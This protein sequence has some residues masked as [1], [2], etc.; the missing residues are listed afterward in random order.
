MKIDV[1]F[2]R[3][4]ARFLGDATA[5]EFTFQVLEEELGPDRPGMDF[6]PGSAL[7]AAGEKPPCLAFGFFH[8][9]SLYLSAQPPDTDKNR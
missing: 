5:P 9:I 1:V 3:G 4:E 8:G 7:L 2:F 6:H